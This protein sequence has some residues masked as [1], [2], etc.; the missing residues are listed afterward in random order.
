[1]QFRY[2]YLFRLRVF[3]NPD[4]SGSCS[5]LQNPVAL[6]SGNRIMF[7]TAAQ[8]A[9]PWKIHVFHLVTRLSGPPALRLVLSPR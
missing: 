8:L 5:Q 9:S 6:R 1:M 3:Q 7:N 2:P 4:Q